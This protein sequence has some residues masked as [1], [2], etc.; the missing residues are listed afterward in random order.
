MVESPT[1]L[2]NSFYLDCGSFPEKLQYSR[3]FVYGWFCWINTSSFKWSKSHS[4]P[5]A[6]CPC[7]MCIL[8]WYDYIDYLT[9]NDRC[10]SCV[11]HFDP[12]R[13]PV[14]FDV[15][16]FL[17]LMLKYLLNF[18]SLGL[19]ERTNLYGKTTEWFPWKDR[20]ALLHTLDISILRL[21]YDI[22]VYS[23]W[24]VCEKYEHL[25]VVECLDAWTTF[26]N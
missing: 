9:A 2:P 25:L 6:P 21:S 15:P 19:Q 4:L 12:V 18:C 17:L 16:F 22:Q 10:S 11:I 24:C 7:P 13:A 1:L 26:E 5:F 8:S 20:D 3:Q 14:S 23:T